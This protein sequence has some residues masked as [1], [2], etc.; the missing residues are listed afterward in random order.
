MTFEK[1]GAMPDRKR[2]VSIHLIT[3]S[4]A[5]LASLLV[6]PIWMSE[7]VTVSSRPDGLHRTFA[8]SPGQPKARLSAARVTTVLQVNAL[9]SENEEQ[10]RADALDKAPENEEQ[11]WADARDEPRI[12]FLLPCSFRKISDRQLIAPRLTLSLCPLRC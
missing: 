2:L 12:S 11:D 9:P 7:F 10:D 8:L 6:A 5:L 4:L 3:S 1:R